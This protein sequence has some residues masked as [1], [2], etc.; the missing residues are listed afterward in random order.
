[1]S[2]GEV[3]DYV[4]GVHLDGIRQVGLCEVFL[5]DDWEVGPTWR[6]SDILKDLIDTAGG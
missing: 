3:I 1:M 4:L 5:N 2:S 6:D